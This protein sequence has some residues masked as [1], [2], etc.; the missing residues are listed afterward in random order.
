LECRLA[1]LPG[2]HTN[3]SDPAGL[4]QA[5]HAAHSWWV[6]VTAWELPAACGW[7]WLPIPPF[8]PATP[9][10][11]LIALLQRMPARIAGMRHWQAAIANSWN[12]K[13]LV[14]S[15]FVLV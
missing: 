2:W 5:F 8:D 9:V 14:P 3:F 12:F 1:C 4:A 13:S 11:V 15:C 10:L 6:A 7:R